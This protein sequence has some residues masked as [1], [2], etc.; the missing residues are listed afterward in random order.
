MVA[1]FN[2][3]VFALAIFPAMGLVT[4]LNHRHHHNGTGRH[5]RRFFD[6]SVLYAMSRVS[7]GS[8]KIAHAVGNDVGER[9]GTVRRSCSFNK[10]GATVA[11]QRIPRKGP[12][13]EY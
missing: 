2:L 6:V 11:G 7:L 9:V 4:I 1:R 3:E 8:S 5:R 12:L 13:P 10:S